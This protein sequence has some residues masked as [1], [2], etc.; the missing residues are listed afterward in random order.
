M[1]N[2]LV[3]VRILSRI[4]NRKIILKNHR[5]LIGLTIIIVN[6][7]VDKIIYKIDTDVY[8]DDL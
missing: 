6:V 3:K 5:P 8:I 2:I 4:I 7:K 1:N